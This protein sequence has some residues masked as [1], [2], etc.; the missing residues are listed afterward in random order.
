MFSLR[1]KGDNESV[2][3]ISF[4]LFFDVTLYSSFKTKQQ[5][6]YV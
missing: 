3:V 2:L 1:N 5:F 6:L 4:H